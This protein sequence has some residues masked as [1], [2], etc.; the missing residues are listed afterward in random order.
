MIRMV[1]ANLVTIYDYIY[2]YRSSTGLKLDRVKGQA[3]YLG[4][5]DHLFSGSRGSLDQTNKTRS[6]QFIKTGMLAA[7]QCVP[8]FLETA[9]VYSS[10]CMSVHLHIPALIT[11]GMIWCDIDHV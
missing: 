2:A 5:K 1:L 8:W 11:S 9:L 10:V 3:A 6:I 4:Q 7:G